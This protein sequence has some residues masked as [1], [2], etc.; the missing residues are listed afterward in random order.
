VFVFSH[1]KAHTHTQPLTLSLWKKLEV[2]TR[3]LNKSKQKKLE[4]ERA[5]ASEVEM[6]NFKDKLVSKINST[7]VPSA[8]SLQNS[9][10]NPFSYFNSTPFSTNKTNTAQH[11]SRSSSLK[12]TAANSNFEVPG[13]LANMFFFLCSSFALEIVFYFLHKEHFI[14]DN[15]FNYSMLISFFD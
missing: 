9:N 4:G 15:A 13:N 1:Q 5:R 8:N 3:V 11:Q 10:L 2:Y 7:V 6:Q 12:L 14:D